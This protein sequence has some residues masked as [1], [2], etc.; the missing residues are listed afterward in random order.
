MKVQAF[1]V[2]AQVN[3]A[4]RQ[5]H[6]PNSF[7]VAM[8]KENTSN[9]P[10]TNF[11]ELFNT[12]VASQAK[13]HEEFNTLSQK[14]KGKDTTTFQNDEVQGPWLTESEKRLKEPLDQMEQLFQKFRWK[15]DAMNLHSLS[16]FLQV[17]APPKFKMPSLDK[18][19][20]TGCPKAHLKMYTRALQPLGATEE[21]LAQ[22]FQNTLIGAAL[23]WFLNLEDSQIPTWEDIANEFYK[24]YKYNIEVDITRRDLETTKQKP[25]ESFSTFITRWRSK[26]A[27]MTNRPNE[28]EQIQM[29]VKNLLPIYHKHLFAQCFPNFKALIVAGTQVE[30]VVNNGI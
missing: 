25:K 22:M 18:F 21:L 4:L 9:E 24:Q 2:P 3:Q 27:Q 26:A 10:M 19:D 15:E 11:H 20:G 14:H 8:V 23:C 12:L 16:L 6:L 5:I 1:K 17:R 7:L 28:E 29:V 30:D 13:L